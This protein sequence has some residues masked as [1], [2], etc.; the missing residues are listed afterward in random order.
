MRQ[1]ERRARTRAALVREASIAFSRDGYES[2]SLDDIVSAAGYSKGAL[3]ANFR[4]KRELFAVVISDVMT[5]AERRTMGVARAAATGAGF[6]DSA[7]EYWREPAAD[8]HAGLI[9]AS[10]SLAA[11]DSEVKVELETLRERQR[12]ILGQALVD[13]GDSPGSALDRAEILARLIDAEVIGRHLRGAPSSRMA[14]G[15]VVG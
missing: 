1:E 12:A 14:F 3:Y 2:A 7:R 6:L 8:L 15:E 5:E 10:W 13:A 9:R 11:V 4:S